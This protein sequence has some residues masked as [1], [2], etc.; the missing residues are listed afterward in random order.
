MSPI[1]LS[2]TRGLEP[3]NLHWLSSVNRDGKFK[4][5]LFILICIK[6]AA[7]NKKKYAK[8]VSRAFN[9]FVYSIGKQN[10]KYKKKKKRPSD[11]LNKGKKLI[12]VKSI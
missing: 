2:L 1:F 4:R 5:R 7:V 12:F 3:R 8:I 6:N 9:Y 10:S 11:Y